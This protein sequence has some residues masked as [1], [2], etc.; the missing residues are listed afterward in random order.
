MSTWNVHTES[1]SCACK[2][3]HQTR[4]HTHTNIHTHTHMLTCA[5]KQMFLNTKVYQNQM[6]PC[7]MITSHAPCVRVTFLCT[8]TQV[9]IY[10]YIY[11]YVYIY[12]YIHTYTYIHIYI[13]IYIYIHMHVCIHIFHPRPHNSQI[14]HNT[15]GH[16][17][18]CLYRSYSSSRGHVRTH[19]CRDTACQT[20][21]RMS[22]QLVCRGHDQ[23]ASTKMCFVVCATILNTF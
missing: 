1:S 16:I 23:G 10:I 5:N 2:H 17:S 6:R 21:C 4:V 14:I 15:K 9:P 11:I 8:Y 18:T 22:V 19:A 20:G 12:I 13:Y 3:V 7:R